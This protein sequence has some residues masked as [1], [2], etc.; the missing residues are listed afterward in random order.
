MTTIDVREGGHTA[1][2]LA[3]AMDSYVLGLACRDPPDP[4][5]VSDWLY[6]S[7]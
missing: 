6:P 4:W 2:N 5:R 3:N 7:I 1:E